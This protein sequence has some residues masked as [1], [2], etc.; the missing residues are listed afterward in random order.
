MLRDYFGWWG[1]KK[2]RLV[3]RGFMVARVV[4]WT[5]SRFNEWIQIRVGDNFRP[6]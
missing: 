5:V 6:F 1:S 4:C 2:R 3:F